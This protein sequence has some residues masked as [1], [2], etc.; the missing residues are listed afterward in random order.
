LGRIGTEGRR[1]LDPHPDAGAAMAAL[2]QLA[3]TKRR[4]G[5]GDRAM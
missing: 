3:R 1:R 2:D 4:R 5:Y